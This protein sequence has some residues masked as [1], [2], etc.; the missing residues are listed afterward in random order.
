MLFFFNFFFIRNCKFCIRI[1]T[2]QNFWKS[3]WPNFLHFFQTNFYFEMYKRFILHINRRR[4]CKQFNY[5]RIKKSK[6]NIELASKI[7]NKT[8]SKKVISHDFLLRGIESNAKFTCHARQYINS[9]TFCPT[10]IFIFRWLIWNII[11]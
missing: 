2:L 9:S 4:E 1:S 5:K 6:K 11:H 8:I 10:M 7:V 3:E